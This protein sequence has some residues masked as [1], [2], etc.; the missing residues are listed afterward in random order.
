MNGHSERTPGPWAVLGLVVASD[1]LG[2]DHLIDEWEPILEQEL[3][4]LG[5]VDRGYLGFGSRS[6][7]DW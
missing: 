6:G 4:G 3:P 2:G 5:Q 1:S 7:S